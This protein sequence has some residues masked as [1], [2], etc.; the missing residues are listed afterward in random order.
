MRSSILCSTCS[1]SSSTGEGGKGEVAKVVLRELTSRNML[2]E[3]DHVSS[4]ETRA[5]NT[6]AWGRNALK[7]RGRISQASPRGTWELTEQGLEEGRDLA[8]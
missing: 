8:I 5:A 4:G 2:S 3:A 1:R 7:Q 6:S